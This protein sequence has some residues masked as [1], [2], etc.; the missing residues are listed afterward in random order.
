MFSRK[1]THLLLQIPTF[2]L[3][4]GSFSKKKH[5]PKFRVPYFPVMPTFLVRFAMAEGN[6]PAA[7]R[8]SPE[9]AGAEERGFLRGGRG[10]DCGVLTFL[11]GLI[12]QGFG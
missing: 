11:R 8:P 4:F 9:A 7:S 5:T 2:S 1:T 6:V 3:F 12:T 10:W